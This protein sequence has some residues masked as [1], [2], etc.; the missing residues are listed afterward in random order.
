[1]FESGDKNL[2]HSGD[3]TDKVLWENG[4]KYFNTKSMLDMHPSLPSTCGEIFVKS[5]RNQIVFT[6]FPDR[7]GTA[8]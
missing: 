3:P 1:M 8:N 6:I 4:Y 7:F 5:K 2:N